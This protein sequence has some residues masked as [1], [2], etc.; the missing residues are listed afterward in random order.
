[1]GVAQGAI[2]TTTNVIW[3]NYFGRAHIGSIRGIVSTSMV[4]SSALGPLPFSLLFG[5]TNDYNTPI[6][7]FI[8]LPIASGLISLL[9]VAPRKS[10]GIVRVGTG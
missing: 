1:M 6:M 7:A 2:M 10:S 4:A 8:G 5:L 9:A 3:P